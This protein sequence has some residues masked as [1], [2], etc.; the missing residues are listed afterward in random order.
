LKLDAGNEGSEYLWSNGATTRI[1]SIQAAG[2][3]PETQNYS[4]KVTNEYGCS[5]TSSISIIYSYSACTG[6]NEPGEITHFLIYPNPSTGISTFIAPEL[7]EDMMA[8]ITNIHGKL[9]RT[10]LLRKSESGS[11]MGTLDLSGYPKGL[12]FVRFWSKS[13]LWNE[14]LVIQ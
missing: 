5:T 8:S 7:P 4:V 9:I 12:Y 6:V 3:V 14:K 1:I 10:F 2:I 13:Q 11:I